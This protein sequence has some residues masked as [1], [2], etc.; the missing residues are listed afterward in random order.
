MDSKNLVPG[1][2]VKVKM[3]DNIPAD[4]RI[5]ELNSISL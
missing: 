2:I 4:M 3:G 1:D 5:I